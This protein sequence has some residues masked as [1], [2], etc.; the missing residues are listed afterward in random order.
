MEE[1][2]RFNP[3]DKVEVDYERNG[4]TLTVEATLLNSQGNTQIIRR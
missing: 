2:G 1:L 3:G 4:R